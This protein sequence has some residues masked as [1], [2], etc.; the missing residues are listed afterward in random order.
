[1]SAKYVSLQHL[2]IKSVLEENFWPKF[3]HCKLWQQKKTVRKLGLHTRNE[4]AIRRKAIRDPIQLL[5]NG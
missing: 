3:V 1:M 5:Y 2:L 4:N